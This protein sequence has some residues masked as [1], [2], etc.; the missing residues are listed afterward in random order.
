MAGRINK[1]K[2][3]G[4]AFVLAFH[5][6][7][8]GFNGNTTFPFQVHIVKQLVLLFTFCYCPSK[9]QQT[10]CKGTFS[11]I[12]MGNNAK[13]SK[14]L[15]GRPNVIAQQRYYFAGCSSGFFDR[16]F[17]FGGHL[18]DKS[19]LTLRQEYYHG[20]YWKHSAR[21]LPTASCSYGRRERPAFSCVV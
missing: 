20:N 3:I 17:M 21:R 19:L 13:I 14:L 7:G 16:F 12:N 9:V 11:V 2:H 8:V 15:H 6:N 4:G 18:R 5:L 10:V 1:V